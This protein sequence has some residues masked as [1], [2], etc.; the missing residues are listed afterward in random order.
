[1]Q[2]PSTG[3]ETRENFTKITFQLEQDED[4]YPP[5][6]AESLW[7]KRVTGHRYRVENI[8][9]FARDVSLG[10]IVEAGEEDGRL[11]VIRRVEASGHSTIRVVLQ[12]EEDVAVLRARLRQLGCDS[13]LSHRPRLIAVDIPPEVKLQPIR[14]MFEQGLADGQW[15]YEE[16]ALAE[17]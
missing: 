1:M 2:N 4:G 15:E 17:E 7:A 13:E 10:D 9:I 16:S 3:S 6:A 12:R 14:E 5:V 11:T 8:P